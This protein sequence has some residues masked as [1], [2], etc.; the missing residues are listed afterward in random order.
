MDENGNMQVVLTL[1]L[2]CC[3]WDEVTGICNVAQC[4]NE[5]R[6]LMS[7][8]KQI[9]KCKTGYYGDLCDKNVDIKVMCG[10]DFITVFVIEEFFQYYKVPLES[11]HL[12]NASCAAQRTNVLGVT[13]YFARTTEDQYLSCGGKPLEKNTTH[14][15]YSLTLMSSPQVLGNIIREPFIN[16]VYTCIYPFRHAVSLAH[17][18]SPYSRE[19]L[20]HI[21]EQEAKVEMLVYTDHTYTDPFQS[22]PMVHLRDKVYVEVK[23]TDPEDVFLLRVNECWVTQDLEPN[24]TGSVHTLLDNGCMKDETATFLSMTPEQTGSNGQSSTIRYSFDMFRFTVEP[25]DL[26]L[27][28]IVHLCSPDDE[29]PCIP[30]CKTITKREAV[31]GD[32]TQGLLSYG[33]I[34]LKMPE[35]LKSDLLMTTVLPMAGI[36]VLGIFLIIIITIA[37]AGNRRLAHLHHN[38]LN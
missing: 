6:C 38:D 2:F 36:W 23:V 30:E 33:P 26:F 10:K 22:T 24:S 17:P 27:H 7:Q 19:T 20:V 34:K 28:C 1:L 14:I 9:C 31:L 15:S 37:R 11:L 4:T 18:V 8:D 25:H 12:P 3:A 21:K 13:Y 29:K 5:T 35:S 32:P 16:I